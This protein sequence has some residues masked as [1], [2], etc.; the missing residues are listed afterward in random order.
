[1]VNLNAEWLLETE[2]NHR[3]P[4]AG[5]IYWSTDAMLNR[6]LPDAMSIHRI[7]ETRFLLSIKT[8]WLL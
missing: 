2:L 1:M 8:S 7:T 4:D 5:L 3:L 6:C